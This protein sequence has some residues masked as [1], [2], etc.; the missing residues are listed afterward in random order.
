[1]IDGRS[2]SAI[3]AQPAVFE[4]YEHPNGGAEGELLRPS[5]ETLKECFGTANETGA[6]Q[7]ILENG[8]IQAMGKWGRHLNKD[9][10]SPGL[11]QACEPLDAIGSNRDAS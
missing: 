11:I 1:M 5:K 6:L 8:S 9:R 7:Y 4:V 10:G 2:E 3:D